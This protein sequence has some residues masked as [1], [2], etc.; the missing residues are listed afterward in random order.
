M[1]RLELLQKQRTNLLQQQELTEFWV[2]YLTHCEGVDIDIQ[3]YYQ[4]RKQEMKDEEAQLTQQLE[5]TNER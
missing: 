5:S 2:V 4:D 3:T 1:D